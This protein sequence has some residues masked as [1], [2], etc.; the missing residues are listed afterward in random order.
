MTKTIHKIT[1][2]SLEI[3]KL[4][5]S[6]AEILCTIESSVLNSFRG[7]A[8]KEI[9]ENMEIP[10]FRKGKVPEKV[11]IQK[12]G[13]LAILQEAAE[14]IIGEAYLAIIEDK[15]IDP[16]GRPEVNILKLAPGNDLEFSIKTA[17][18]P[19]ITLPDYKKIAGI[20]MKKEL[21]V[22]DLT[23]KEL[24]AA[25]KEIQGFYTPKTADGKPGVAPLLTE[26]F[27]KSLGQ[28]ESLEDFKKKIGDNIKKDKKEKAEEKRR[29]AI[30]EKILEGTKT[31]IPKILVESELDKMFSQF[32]ADVKAAG[33][34][35]KEYFEKVKKT[36]ADIRKEWEDG[37]K[38]K[39]TMQLILNEMAK[40]EKIIADETEVH[41]FA[42]QVLAEY[43]DADHRAA[44]VYAETMLTN[45]KVLMFLEEQK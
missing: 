36:E 33:L 9:Q 7:K 4:A 40:L 17:L 15:K 22:E 25:F 44:H 27:V 43:K 12:I 26:E 38:K 24:D 28:F 8:L 34:T 1:W 30:L 23:E 5:G 11:I 35:M 2:K 31:E 20:E 6:E 19:E 21:V 14:M 37:A 18:V 42:H 3:K 29:I 39:A 16:I 41:E 13:E 45:K 32:E 10:G